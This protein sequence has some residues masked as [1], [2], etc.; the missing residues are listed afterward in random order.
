MAPESQDM[1]QEAEKV[2]GNP[3]Y[4]EKGNDVVGKW[5]TYGVVRSLFDQALTD[6]LVVVSGLKI[7]KS[8]AGEAGAHVG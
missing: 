2:S 5:M 4:D 8:V 7:Q 6:L 1:F 3:I